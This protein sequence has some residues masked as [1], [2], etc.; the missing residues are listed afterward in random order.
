MVNGR[1]STAINWLTSPLTSSPEPTPEAES[2]PVLALT[3]GKLTATAIPSLWT[4][5]ILLSAAG[6]QSFKH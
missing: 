5:N 3:L 4:S 6:W 1:C 2:V